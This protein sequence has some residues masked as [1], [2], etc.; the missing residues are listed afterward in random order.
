LEYGPGGFL[1]GRYRREDRSLIGAGKTCRTRRSL[2]PAVGYQEI[3]RLSLPS[4]VPADQLPLAYLP[5]ELLDQVDGYQLLSDK[6]ILYRRGTG[7]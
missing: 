2:L 7:R 1:F 6:M 5:S 4:D 3:T